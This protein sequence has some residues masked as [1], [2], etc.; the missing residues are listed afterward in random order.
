MIQRCISVVHEMLYM[1]YCA[2]KTSEFFAALRL[3][4]TRC[5]LSLLPNGVFPDTMETDIETNTDRR[6]PRFRHVCDCPRPFFI[7]AKITLLNGD[8]ALD[9]FAA[10]SRR[11]LQEALNAVDP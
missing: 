4:G 2:Q 10:Q 8:M 9:R 11:L 1:K 7:G 3:N 5:S 6:L